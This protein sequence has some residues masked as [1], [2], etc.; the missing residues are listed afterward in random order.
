MAWL[1]ERSVAPGIRMI[2]LNH[3]G[4][5]LEHL[6]PCILCTPGTQYARCKMLQSIPSTRG[7]SDI[8]Y[9]FIIPH[10]VIVLVV[11]NRGDYLY[12]YLYIYIYTIRQCATQNIYYIVR[13][14]LHDIPFLLLQLTSHLHALHATHYV[15]TCYIRHT[16][17][18]TPKSLMRYVNPEVPSR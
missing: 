18:S 17:Y 5:S 6:R 16:T 8:Q 15:T 10:I 2:Q 3:V 12:I 4:Q 7:T 9:S 11:S 14:T 13:S 1:V